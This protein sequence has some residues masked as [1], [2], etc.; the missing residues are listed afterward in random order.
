MSGM[1]ITNMKH[2]PTDRIPGKQMEVL[3]PWAHLSRY[4]KAK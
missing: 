4:L 2:F 3:N 1:I